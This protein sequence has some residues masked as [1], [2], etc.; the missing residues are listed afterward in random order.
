VLFIEVVQLDLKGSNDNLVMQG[1]LTIYLS[2]NLSTTTMS[3]RPAGSS[4]ALTSL[5][6]YDSS[7]SVN[8]ASVD[9]ASVDSYSVDNYSVNNYSVNNYL[10]NN[11]SVD[12]C[13]VDNCSVDNYSV[14]NY[15]VDNYSV[16]IA[17][18]YTV[19]VN[20][21]SVSELYSPSIPTTI[22]PGTDL[23]QQ[24]SLPNIPT[25]PVSSGD[26]SIADRSQSPPRPS[27]PGVVSPGPPITNA[28]HNL[29]ANEDQYGPLPEG[30]ESGIDPLGLTYYVNHH[31][32]SIGGPNTQR[33]G[34]AQSENAAV[35][36]AG[37]GTT[38][39]G[40]GSLP[41]GWEE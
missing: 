40:S 2:T 27:A 15:S 38:T 33:S 21:A 7:R 29:S 41:A 12:N 19:S 6:S 3:S 39:A 10:I 35:V 24:Q 31:T 1:K 4:L 28:Q 18:V 26:T 14:D 13:S 34:I 23:E 16:N 17:S 20:S 25:R 11:H 36:G 5:P 37:G 22:M 9:N 30:W 32:S 8:N